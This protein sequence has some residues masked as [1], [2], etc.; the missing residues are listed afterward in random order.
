MACCGQKRQSMSTSGAVGTRASAPS[1]ATAAIAAAAQQ[2]DVRL[3]YR[4]R[5]GFAM[6]SVRTGR[7]YAC[8]TTG[9]I[10]SVDPR[11]AEPLIRTRLFSR[12]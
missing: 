9:A 2:G 10:I 11:D 6:R 7:A 5:G 1:R 12:A 3:V 4:G 8:G